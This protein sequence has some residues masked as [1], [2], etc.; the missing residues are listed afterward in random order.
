MA[1]LRWGNTYYQDIMT[2]E[3]RE[4]LLIEWSVTSSKI[5]EQIEKEYLER[6]G[7]LQSQAHWEQHLVK[8]LN[9]EQSWR[10]RG[11]L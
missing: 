6:C 5:R 7:S 4:D 9:L 10:R 3:Q 2:E 11:L 1:V 8:A